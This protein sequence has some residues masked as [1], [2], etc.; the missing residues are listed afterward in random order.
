MYSLPSL[1]ESKDKGM[2]GTWLTDDRFARKS[3]VRWRN[4]RA[5]QM[6]H[7]GEMEE[8]SRQSGTSMKISQPLLG[9][10]QGGERNGSVSRLK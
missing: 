2:I 9:R 5:G 1:T 6:D 4:W 3:N 7:E 10:L 8:L